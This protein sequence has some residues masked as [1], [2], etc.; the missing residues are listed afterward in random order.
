LRLLARLSLTRVSKNRQ[1]RRR[2][3]SSAGCSG[4]IPGSASLRAE[5]ADDEREK[6]CYALI[7]SAPRRAF[8]HFKVALRAAA[9]MDPLDGGF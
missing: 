9:E 8:D 7:S 1:M 6:L 3:H 4:V 5:P 2:L